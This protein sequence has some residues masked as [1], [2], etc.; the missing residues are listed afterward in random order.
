MESSWF[1][2]LGSCR[3]DVELRDSLKGTKLK[4]P[5]ERKMSRFN[6]ALLMSCVFQDE[7]NVVCLIYFMCFSFYVMLFLQ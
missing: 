2:V 3:Q 4:M 7:N 5:E 6:P 1:V